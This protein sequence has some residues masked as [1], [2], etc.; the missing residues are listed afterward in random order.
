MADPLSAAIDDMP[1][2]QPHAIKAEAE[3][4]KQTTDGL[5]DRYGNA[6]D[7]LKHE[8]NP[9]GTPRLT[10]AGNLARKRGRGAESF[11]AGPAPYAQPG[12]RIAGKYAAELMFTV[13]Q[14]IGGD[15]WVPLIDEKVGLNERAG[16]TDAFGAYFE[17]Q[18]WDDIPPGYA[19]TI[20]LVGYVSPRLFMPKTKSRL[21]RIK[22]WVVARYVNFRLRRQGGDARF[23]NGDDGKRKD[24]VGQAFGAE[25]PAKT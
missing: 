19:L 22:E 17:A 4:T 14:L 16:L 9:D 3:R 1:E 6:F 18:G 23:D 10:N 8:T 25:T 24:D 13:G 7:P 12:P 15:E 20:A 5:S 21:T 11:V 2:P